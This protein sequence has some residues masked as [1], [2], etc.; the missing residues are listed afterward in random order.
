MNKEIVARGD[1]LILRILDEDQKVL[2]ETRGILRTSEVCRRLRVG[3]RQL[4]RYVET[5][6]L[7]PCAR[8]LGELLFEPAAV[9]RFGRPRRGRGAQLPEFLAPLVWSYRL[10]DLDAVRDEDTLLGGVLDRGGWESWQWAWRVYGP[11]RIRRFLIERGVRW[12]SPKAR[13]FWCLVLNVAE[14]ELSRPPFA[15]HSEVWPP[16]AHEPLAA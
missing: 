6:R 3:R 9:A 5:G 8:V 16:R 14:R 10:K 15:T 7:A 4:Y 13:A 12:L 1:A 11:K 2:R